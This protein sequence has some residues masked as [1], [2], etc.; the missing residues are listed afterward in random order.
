MFL[1][2]KKKYLEEFLTLVWIKTLVSAGEKKRYLEAFLT[3][4]WIKPL[5]SAAEKKVFRAV[6]DT[7]LDKNLQPRDPH[8][9]SS[10]FSHTIDIPGC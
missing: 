7:C 4:V 6:S 1:L 8:L 10:I 9:F 2:V 3:L 5:V